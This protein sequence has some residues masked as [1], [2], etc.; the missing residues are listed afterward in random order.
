MNLSTI[1]NSLLQNFKKELEKEE[2]I[3]LIKQDLLR[4]IIKYTMDELYPYF[5]K[6]II[7]ITAIL[8]FLIIVIFLNLKIMLKYHN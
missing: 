6:G 2:N 1:T 4:P 3:I 7:L 8:L 5:F